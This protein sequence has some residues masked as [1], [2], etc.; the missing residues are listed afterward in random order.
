MDKYEMHRDTESGELVTLEQLQ[1]EYDAMPEEDK[2]GRTFG[3]WIADCLSK[4]G[5]LQ[6]VKP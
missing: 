2:N 1:S 3:Q 5:F 6:E 4:N